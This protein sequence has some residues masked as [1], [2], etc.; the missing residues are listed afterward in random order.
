MKAT[1]T[2]TPGIMHLVLNAS[3]RGRSVYEDRFVRAVD[4]NG[5]HVLGIQFP[6]NDVEM[7]TQWFCKM[8]ESTAPAEIWLDVDFDAL[9]KVQVEIDVPDTDPDLDEFGKGL[10]DI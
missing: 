2:N 3:G 9:N 6:H 4:P 10:V 1:V 8:R 7:R 5:T